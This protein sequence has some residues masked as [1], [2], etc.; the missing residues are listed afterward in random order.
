MSLASY[1]GVA[2]VHDKVAEHGASSIVGQ[3]TGHQAPPLS[4]DPALAVQSLS[5][6]SRFFAAGRPVIGPLGPQPRGMLKKHH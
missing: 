6:S 2:V 3:E 5:V 4:H 1:G